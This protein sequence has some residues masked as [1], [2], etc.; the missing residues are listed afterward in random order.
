MWDEEWGRQLLPKLLFNTGD[1]I[2][3]PEMMPYI[4]DTM[5]DWDTLGVPYEV[6]DQDEIRYRWPV[7]GPEHE[8]GVGLYEP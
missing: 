3:R 5:V 2:M 1:L 6:L 7:I 4:E 8:I